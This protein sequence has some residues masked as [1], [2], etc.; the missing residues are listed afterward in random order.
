MKVGGTSKSLRVRQGCDD[1][2]L[3]A[4]T[5]VELEGTVLGVGRWRGIGLEVSVLD[6]IAKVGRVFQKLSSQFP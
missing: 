1:C 3:P 6:P 2:Q 4:A 5:G